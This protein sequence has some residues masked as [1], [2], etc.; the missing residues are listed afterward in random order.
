MGSVDEIPADPGRR[1]EFVRWQLCRMAA[2]ARL[3]S[4]ALVV[5]RH[6]RSCEDC[7]A[8]LDELAAARLW[9]SADTARQPADW[10]DGEL[11]RE[12]RR[13]LVAEL[14]ARLARDLLDKAGARAGRARMDI[15]DDLRRVQLLRR[16]SSQPEARWQRVRASLRRPDAQVPVGDLLELATQ[17]D[18]LGLDLALAW[19]AHLWRDGQRDRAQREA[20]RFLAHTDGLGIDP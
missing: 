11:G 2:G 4:S 9:L 18:P 6:V 12:A 17:L 7:D 3:R 5:A 16:V 15:R 19:L 1:C 8:Y 20:D 14:E 10:E 13:A